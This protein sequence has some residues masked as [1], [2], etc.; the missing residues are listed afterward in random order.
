M[1]Y[2]DYPWNIE[3]FS[4]TATGIYIFRLYFLNKLFI[5]LF[6]LCFCHCSFRLKM[7]SCVQCAEF[8]QGWRSILVGFAARFSMRTV[9]RSKASCMARRRWMH[10]G[11][12]IQKLVGVAQNVYVPC[13][14]VFWTW[15]KGFKITCQWAQELSTLLRGGGGGGGGGGA[16]HP[17]ISF[18]IDAPPWS[19]TWNQK[20]LSLFV[21]RRIFLPFWQMKKCKIL[22]KVLTG[23]MSTKVWHLCHSC[24]GEF[25]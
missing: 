2:M 12:Q 10:S 6:C 4:Q 19:W 11:E 24:K 1:D 8:T 7:M 15:L 17:I 23:W 16:C 25:W 21:S 14:I 5:S 20:E 9:S 3:V 22:L 18:S 13:L